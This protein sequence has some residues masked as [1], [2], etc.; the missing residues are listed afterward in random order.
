MTSLVR[1]RRGRLSF[2][3]C[4]ADN[5]DNFPGRRYVINLSR[6]GR[7]AITSTALERPRR[8]NRE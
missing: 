4:D 6:G 5:L 8:N 7:D 3:G 1:H 2:V